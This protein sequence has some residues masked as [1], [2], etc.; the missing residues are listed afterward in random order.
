MA[1]KPTKAC[2][3]MIFLLSREGLS[4]PHLIWLVARQGGRHPRVFVVMHNYPYDIHFESAYRMPTLEVRASNSRDAVRLQLGSL[5]RGHSG[6]VQ[7]NQVSREAASW[8]HH[9]YP[10]RLWWSLD[11]YYPSSNHC[12]FKSVLCAL[13]TTSKAMNHIRLD[14]MSFMVSSQGMRMGTGQA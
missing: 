10:D 9:I 13:W 14:E 12:N 7:L 8:L 6:M 4:R 2:N 5:S 3:W 11:S 1:G